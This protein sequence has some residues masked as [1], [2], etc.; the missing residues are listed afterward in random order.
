MFIVDIL[1]IPFFLYS[2]IYIGIYLGRLDI[3]TFFNSKDEWW[4]YDK[5]NSNQHEDH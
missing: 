1:H 3:I 2:Y 5:N 4:F